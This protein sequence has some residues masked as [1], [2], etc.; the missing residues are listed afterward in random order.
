[1]D[2]LFYSLYSALSCRPS[3]RSLI[4]LVVAFGTSLTSR[5]AVAARFGI[6]GDFWLNLVL[7]I[8]GYIPGARSIISPHSPAA[9]LTSHHAQVTHTTSTFR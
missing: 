8:C 3:V 5:E 9:D 4:A 6:G 7:T 1:M 2:M